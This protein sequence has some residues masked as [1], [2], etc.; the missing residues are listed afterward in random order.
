MIKTI[1]KFERNYRLLLKEVITSGVA[2]E[3]RTGVWAFTKFNKSLEIDMQDGFPMITGKK[4]F[5]KIC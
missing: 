1:N 4:I 5:F 2:K 3:N